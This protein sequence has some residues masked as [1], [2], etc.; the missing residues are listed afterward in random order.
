MVGTKEICNY[1]VKNDEVKVIIFPSAGRKQLFAFALLARANITNE[2]LKERK[3]IL[4]SIKEF[5]REIDLIEK[6]DESIEKDSILFSFR[7]LS[8]HPLFVGLPSSYLTSKLDT[9]LMQEY[10]DI[11]IYSYQRSALDYRI[12]QWN[13]TLAMEM[14]EN[15]QVL[16]KYF[17]EV[18]YE[19]PSKST[20]RYLVDTEDIISIKNGQKITKSSTQE[21]LM[22]PVNQI[23]EI[24]LLLQIDDEINDDSLLEPREIG[25]T[26]ITNEFE[27]VLIEEAL[28]VH[29][30]DKWRVLFAPDETI[31]VIYSGPRGDKIEERYVRSL[32]TGDRVLYIH[33]QKSQRLYELI[34]SRIHNNPAIEVHLALIRRWHDDFILSMQQKYESTGMNL[35]DLL[36]DLLDEIKNRGSKLTSIVTLNSWLRGYV[37]SPKDPEDLR[38]LSESL[39]MTFTLEYY[40][41]INIAA[42]RLRNIHRNLSRSLPHYILQKYKGV[43]EDN[44][45]I[46]ESIDDELGLTLQDFIDSVIVLQVI[47][48]NKKVGPFYRDGLG[49]LEKEE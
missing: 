33:G 35:D 49:K 45:G 44:E 26:S 2:D 4:M 40:K 47:S 36:Y 21:P 1:E 8:I 48:L 46:N 32:E 14:S 17:F 12:E 18:P 30:D 13:N 9:V 10:L 24:A 27:N 5:R 7:N 6:S 28:E 19:L 25:E 29:F 20:S 11:L 37:L 23:E 42:E 34:I 3:I 31:N 39:N 15:I 43:I 22:Q 41:R 38:R 16:Y